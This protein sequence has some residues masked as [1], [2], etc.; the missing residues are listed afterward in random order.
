MKRISY[1]FK[2]CIIL[3]MSKMRLTTGFEQ[4]GHIC[5]FPSYELL[6]IYSMLHLLSALIIIKRLINFFRLLQRFYSREEG[7]SSPNGTF[8]KDGR[9]YPLSIFSTLPAFAFFLGLNAPFIFTQTGRAVYWRLAL[10]GTIVSWA[11]VTIR[12]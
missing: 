1:S 3:K 2:W 11:W 7:T 12:R 4:M 5:L 6:T 9:C 10:A 8:G